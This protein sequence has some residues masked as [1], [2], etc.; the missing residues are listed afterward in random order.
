MASTAA[1]GVNALKVVRENL[2]AIEKTVDM[3][4]E[5]LDHTDVYMAQK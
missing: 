3:I 2:G 5:R 1:L 4:A